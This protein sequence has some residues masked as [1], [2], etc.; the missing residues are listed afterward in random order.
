LAWLEEFDIEDGFCQELVIDNGWLPDF[1][2][3]NPFSARAGPSPGDDVSPGNPPDA[4]TELST[5]VWHWRKG[6]V[7]RG[8]L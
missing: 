3:Q 5:P 1:T 8:K 2:R 4:G 7:E 6:F